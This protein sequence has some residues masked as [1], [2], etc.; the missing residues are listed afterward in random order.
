MKPNDESGTFHQ[1]KEKCAGKSI[2]FY[3]FA[4]DIDNASFK[5]AAGDHFQYS[6]DEGG[7]SR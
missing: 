7:R 2:K 5:L 4:I 6:D 1:A 3:A